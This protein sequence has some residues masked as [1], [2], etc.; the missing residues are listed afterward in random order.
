M[1]D[2]AIAE[3]IAAFGQLDILVNNAGTVRARRRPI[4]ATTIGTWS[5]RST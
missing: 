5:S 4:M 2:R 3:A 1:S